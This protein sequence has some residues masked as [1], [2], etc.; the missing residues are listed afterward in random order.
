MTVALPSAGQQATGE[1]RAV[2][3]S[4]GAM[5]AGKLVHLGLNVV[6]SLMLIRALGPAEYG[7]YIF[8]L[9]FSALFGLISD[10]GI[11]KVAVRDMSRSPTRAGEILGTSMLARLGLAG[12]AWVGAQIVLAL[13]DARA[14][15]R[16]AVGIASLQMVTDALL[17]IVAVFQF[18]LAMQYEALVSAGAQVI[19]SALIISLI[20]L[21]GGLWALVAAPV[22]SGVCGAGFAAWLARRNFPERPGFDRQLLG[23]MMR[24]ALPVGLT[25]LLAVVYLKVDGVLLGVLA[26]REDVGLYGAAQKPIEYLLAGSAVILVPLFPLLSRFCG[27]DP[28]AFRQVYRRGSQVI[29]CLTLPI[30]VGLLFLGQP[31]VQTLYASAFSASAQPLVVLA[32]ALVAMVYNVFQ[33]FTLLAGN[34]QRVALLYDAA[35]LAVNLG[36]N[37]FL[38]PRM[39]YQGPA[40]AAL[41]TS[42]FVLASASIATHRVMGVVFD[43]LGLG[44]VVL[45]NALFGLVLWL[46]VRA[47]LPWIAAGILASAIYPICLLL[48]RATSISEIQD[49]L[50]T[51]RA[52][53][54]HPAA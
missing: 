3:V 50:A 5:I 39:G 13:M 24:D 32:A 37:I 18:R 21:H 20:W 12:V 52:L 41:V 1:A 44:R 15:V 10:F 8:V 36:L 9:S 29:L 53:A 19:D 42:L 7:D 35:G 46:L 47:G 28:V 43:P 45:A 22:V 16:V 23:P 31:I 17:S 30:P 33:G 2:A 4:A 38:I 51:R 26:T 6:T 48:V 49:L 25:L 40:I 14:E 11:T 27:S 54:H 34:H